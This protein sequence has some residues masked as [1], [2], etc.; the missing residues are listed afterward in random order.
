MQTRV[1]L[2]QTRKSKSNYKSVSRV[3]GSQKECFELALANFLKKEL[4]YVSSGGVVIQGDFSGP[5]DYV[6]D[7]FGL[8]VRR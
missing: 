6:M 7:R 5:L 3:T 2:K 1:I 4:G 8:A